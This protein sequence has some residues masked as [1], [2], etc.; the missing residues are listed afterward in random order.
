[1]DAVALV[2]ELDQLLPGFADYVKS[3]DNL[4]DS[5]TACGVFAACSHFVSERSVSAATWAPLAMFLNAA[6]SGS[7]EA[8]VEAACTCF[9]ENI[10]DAGHPLKAFLVGN[11]LSF[12]EQWE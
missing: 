12:W 8:V 10:A 5:G 7:D 4:F 6:V 3:G 1:M 9:L 2:A 11:A